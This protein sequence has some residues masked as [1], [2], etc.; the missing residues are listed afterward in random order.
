MAIALNNTHWE[1]IC[2][3]ASTILEMVSILCREE[4]TTMQQ[5]C[6]NDISDA[7]SRLL[8]LS[9]VLS[10][11]ENKTRKTG[12]PPYIL[13]VEDNDIIATVENALL[14]QLNCDVDIAVNAANAL[15]LST[16]NQYDLILLDINLPDISGIE[17]AKTLR[18][19]LKE[20]CPP[21]I[22][23][24]TLSSDETISACLASGIQRVFTKPAS[25]DTF[26]HILTSLNLLEGASNA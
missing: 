10:P 14:N 6:V 26:K 17:L 11:R 1:D 25:L 23:I 16:T 4:L 13:L 2:Y 21:L 5:A 20:Q 18:L 12:T 24:T 3:P 15:A 8:M 7:A 9:N 19:C 22:A